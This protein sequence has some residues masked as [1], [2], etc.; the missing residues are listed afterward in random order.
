VSSRKIAKDLVKHPIAEIE[1]L[2]APYPKTGAT[3]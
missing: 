1:R 3:A 2:I